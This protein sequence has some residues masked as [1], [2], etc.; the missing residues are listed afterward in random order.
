MGSWCGH[1]RRCPSVVL[2]LERVHK[3][4]RGLAG[5]R[6]VDF[7]HKSRVLRGHLYIAGFVCHGGLL[8]VTEKGILRSC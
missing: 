3:A 1:E 6:G 8:S 2:R 5:A 4:P 7:F